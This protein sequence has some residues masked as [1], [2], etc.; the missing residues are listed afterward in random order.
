GP[1]LRKGASETLDD[2]VGVMAEPSSYKDTNNDGVW[3][4]LWDGTSAVG[5]ART[6]DLGSD[7]YNYY[8][9]VD[10]GEI[11]NHPVNGAC[12][13][14]RAVLGTPWLS[15]R[16]K[17]LPDGVTERGQSDALLDQ[18]I[19]VPDWYY[20]APYNG[21]NARFRNYE[22]R[23]S[24]AGTNIGGSLAAS[25]AALFTEGR[26]E[27]AVWIM[28]L[29][30]DGAAGASNPIYDINGSDIAPANPYAVDAGGY[31]EPVDG[32]GGPICTDPSSPNYP[33][34]NNSTGGYG[35]FGLCPYGT[36]T[37][38]SQLLTGSSF[39]SC[40]DL[41]PQTRHYCGQVA[42]IPDQALDKDTSATGCINYYDVDDYA[43]DWADWVAVADLPN[44][45]SGGT[46]GRVGDQLLPT[47]FTIGFGLNYNN[48]QGVTC[49]TDDCIRGL[50]AG[51]GDNSGLQRLRNGD[52]LGEELLRYIADVGDNFEIDNDYWQLHASNAALYPGSALTNTCTGG[53]TDRLGNCVNLGAPEWG[54]FGACETETTTHTGTWNPRAPLQSCG[55]Y[56][57]A[58]SGQQLEDVFNQIASRMFTRLSQ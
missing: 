5:L 14:D 56:Y 34:P 10:I 9:G 7:P 38:P 54:T 47:I 6:Y 52:F 20:G 27:G 1:L 33:C 19:T 22:Y 18:V 55:N 21:L 51:T 50:T 48:G 40:S 31:L 43:R 2:V 26:R 42:Y 23:A 32:I 4:H 57:V 45:L 30:S 49:A 12:P 37:N 13:F 16:S 28:V 25:S 36:S 29:L 3:D 46:T 17:L 44:A 15:T 58:A 41:Q 11:T 8:S 24:C 35:F 39:P 53:A